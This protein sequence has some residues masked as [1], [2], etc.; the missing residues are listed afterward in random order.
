MVCCLYENDR[1]EEAKCS[2]QHCHM[3]EVGEFILAYVSV[4]IC[5]NLKDS[6]MVVVSNNLELVFN[7]EGNRKMT[8]TTAMEWKLT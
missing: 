5:G 8:T 4:R 7:H 6:E 2:P 3:R 1:C